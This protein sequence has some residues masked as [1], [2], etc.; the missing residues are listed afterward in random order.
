MYGCSSLT[1]I[2]IPEGVTNIGE[3]AFDECSKLQRIEVDEQNNSYKSI[4]GILYDKSENKLIRCPEGKEESFNISTNITS[5]EMGAFENC[6][7]TNIDI[8]QNVTSISNSAFAYCR[9]LISISLPDNITSIEDMTFYFCESL[10][11]IDI[12]NKI[13]SIGEEAFRNCNSIT[14]IDIPNSVIN[15]GSRVFFG[16]N[17]NQTINVQFKESEI[18]ETWDS[19][20]SYYAYGDNPAKAQINYLP[21]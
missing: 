15:M 12:S 9:N 5:I 7:L 2:D 6:G 1:N 3:R 10:R 19:K 21:E 11:S 14:S 8:P 20:W 4:D 17:Q 13:T 18:P 16:W